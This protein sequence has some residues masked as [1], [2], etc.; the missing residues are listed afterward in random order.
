MDVAL[1]IDIGGT[2]MKAAPVDVATGR[3]LG[4]RFRIPTPQPSTPEAMATVVRDLDRHFTD[5]TGGTGPVGVAFPAVVRGGVVHS[6]ANIDTSWMGADAASAFSE[7]VGR[8]VVVVNDADAAGIA[9]MSFGAGRGRSGLV[10]TL[11]L[12]T[13]I[14][15]GMFMDGT[16]VPNTEFGH[17]EF[18]GDSVERYAA[19]S[20]MERED[21]AWEDWADRVGE[22]LEM[23][24]RLF[25]PDMVIL[26]G[27]VS[28]EP[29]RWFHRIDTR[30]E[31][32]IASMAN[33]AGVVGAAMAAV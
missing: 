33:H 13:G 12:G 5:I 1:G 23:V 26:G 14:G 18:R 24:D 25:S 21:L 22:F 6:A 28:R 10:I 29:E 32:V 30:F 15:S 19:A 16:L 9:E 3:L 17:L 7:A 20:A 11:T 2:G 4:E 8:P 31:T 27:G